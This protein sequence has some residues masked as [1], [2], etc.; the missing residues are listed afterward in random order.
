M[1]NPPVSM[2]IGTNRREEFQLVRNLAPAFCKTHSTKLQ[3]SV[4]CLVIQMFCSQVSTV[5]ISTTSHRV[6]TTRR[7]NH[8]DGVAICLIRPA[9]HRIAMARPAVASSLIS[10]LGLSTPSPNP[11]ALTSTP[12]CCKITP[13][14][15]IIET[16]PIPAAAALTAA[17]N[18]ASALERLT[19]ACVVDVDF[20]RCFHVK[21]SCRNSCLFLLC[22]HPAKFESL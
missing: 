20:R 10:R 16:Q 18:S 21:K 6:T 19:T 3:V 14:S 17:L 1:D 12:C 22:R 5:V 11:F 2:L 15:R 4:H 7:C 8:S 9:P 13:R